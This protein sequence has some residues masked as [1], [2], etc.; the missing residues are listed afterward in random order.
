M[1]LDA[2]RRRKNCV[3]SCKKCATRINEFLAMK[4]WTSKISTKLHYAGRIE[5]SAKIRASPY[6]NFGIYVTSR[7]YFLDKIDKFDR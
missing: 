3:A 5:P 1:F 2:S 6:R 7:V 4:Y